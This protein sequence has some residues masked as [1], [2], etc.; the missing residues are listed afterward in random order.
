MQE[1][2]WYVMYTASRSE[3]K[4]AERLKERG[5][6]V[7]LPIVEAYFLQTLLLNF[8]LMNSVAGQKSWRSH[9]FLFVPQQLTIYAKRPGLVLLIVCPNQFLRLQVCLCLN[10]YDKKDRVQPIV[11]P[12]TS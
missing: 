9:G 12:T 6:D 10:K 3:K 11:T 4:V 7:Y 2:K 1:L 8:V 5:L